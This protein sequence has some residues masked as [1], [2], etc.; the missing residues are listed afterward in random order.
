MKEGIAGK[1]IYRKDY[2]AYPWIVRHLDLHFDIGIETTTVRAEMEFQLKDGIES[3]GCIV[4]NGSDLQLLSLTLD[5]R[6]LTAEDYVIEGETLSIPTGLD[7][8]VL[9]SEVIIHPGSNSALEGLYLSG[10]FLL[11]QCE[12]QGFRKITWFPDRPDVMTTY[13]VTIEADK[14]G[15]PVMLSNGN[16]QDGGELPGGRHW[17]RWE[18]KKK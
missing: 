10:E 6:L 9:K 3:G 11:T 2:T 14:S 8:C 5:D 4:L 13:R 15:F 1:P 17:V 16:L 12:A 7:R 18:E